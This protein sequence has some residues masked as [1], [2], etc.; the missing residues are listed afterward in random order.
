MTEL[1]TESQFDTLADFASRARLFITALDGG[2]IE[3][4]YEIATEGKSL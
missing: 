4:A 1:T 3:T 2:D